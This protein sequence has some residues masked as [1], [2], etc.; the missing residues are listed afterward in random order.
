MTHDLSLH[1]SS[2]QA[3]SGHGYTEGLIE[4]VGFILVVFNYLINYTLVLYHFS[5]VYQLITK[6][7]NDTWEIHPMGILFI[8]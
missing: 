2:G 8:L 1:S 3:F 5:Y 6:I 4:E 7:V